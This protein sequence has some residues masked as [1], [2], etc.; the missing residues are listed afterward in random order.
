MQSVYLRQQRQILVDLPR[1]DTSAFHQGILIAAKR[2]IGHAV[3]LV[4][5][6]RA[7]T[8][9]VQPARRATTTLLQIASAVSAK[10]ATAGPIA[11]AFGARNTA[12]H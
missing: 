5:G 9:A 4:A 11:F 1:L 6:R 12:W 8:A 2:R 10:D 3:E 7:A